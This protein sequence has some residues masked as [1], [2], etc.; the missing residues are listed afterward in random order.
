MKIRRTA[1]AKRPAREIDIKRNRAAR[2]QQ[3]ELQDRY[4]R[5]PVFPAPEDDT[6]KYTP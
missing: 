6:G 1:P 3:Q 4:A 5:R 2:K